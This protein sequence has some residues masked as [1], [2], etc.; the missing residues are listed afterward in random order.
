MPQDAM[1]FMFESTY[2][3]KLT[4]WALEE[5]PLDEKYTECWDDLKNNFDPNW[6]PSK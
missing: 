2:V 6:T 3:M 1:A 5:A 4:K